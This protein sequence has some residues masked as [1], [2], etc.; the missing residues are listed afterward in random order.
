LHHALMDGANSLKLMT[1]SPDRAESFR[2]PFWAT[3]S[4]HTLERRPRHRRAPEGWPARVEKEVQALPTLLRGLSTVVTSALGVADDPN[5]TSLA[6][7]PRT[8]F[9]V[10]VGEQRRV[11]THSASLARIHAIGRAAGGTVNDV[12]LAACSGALRRYLLERG[13]LPERSLIAAVPMALHHEEGAAS[14]NAVT[15]LNARLGTDIEDVRERFDV[16]RRTT[17]SGKAHLK[18]MT[19]TAALRYTMIVSSPVALGWLPGVNALVRPVT[20]LIVSNLAGPRDPLYFHG[21]EM[22]AWYPVS[23]IGHGMALNITVLS[24]AGQL[25]FGLVACRDSVPSMQ[26]L[27]LHIGEALDELEATFLVDRPRRS[28]KTARGG[29]TKRRRASRNTD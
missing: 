18:R 27:A 5:L 12:V 20:N 22:V 3:E 7:A 19:E 6:E 24:Y 26:R 4:G 2:P 13:A 29:Q 1:L 23:Q 17:E 10:R 25:Y 8:L 16:I 21:A 15:T 14:G 9:N 11:A 28:R